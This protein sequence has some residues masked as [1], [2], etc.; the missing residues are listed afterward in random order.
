MQFKEH[1]SKKKKKEHQSTKSHIFILYLL[2]S[3]NFTNLSKNKNYKSSEK[4]KHNMLFC[5][6]LLK[7]WLK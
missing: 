1:Q 5:I 7:N 2:Y 3:S 6:I 4:K